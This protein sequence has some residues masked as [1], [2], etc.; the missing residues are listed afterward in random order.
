LGKGTGDFTNVHVICQV[1]NSAKIHSGTLPHTPAT[2]AY[3]APSTFTSCASWGQEIMILASQSTS[4]RTKNVDSLEFIALA[5]HGPYG[6]LQHRSYEGGTLCEPQTTQ[7]KGPLT[8]RMRRMY[9]CA[10]EVEVEDKSDQLERGE[11]PAL[12]HDECPRESEPS[13]RATTNEPVS[14]RLIPKFRP[15]KN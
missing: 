5:R 15:S 10:V 12:S 7:Q 1:L 3:A 4:L 9:P 2:T 14:H 13:E 6:S 8:E 11:Q